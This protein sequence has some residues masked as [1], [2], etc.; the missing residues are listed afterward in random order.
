MSRPSASGHPAQDKQNQGVY[1]FVVAIVC[2]RNQ[3]KKREPS[4]PS[5]HPQKGKKLSRSGQRRRAE[6]VDLQ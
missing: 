2:T 5:T 6:F 4:R 3:S 1:S